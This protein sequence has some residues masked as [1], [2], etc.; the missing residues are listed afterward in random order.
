M[1]VTGVAGAFVELDRQERSVPRC[2]RN[3]SG[4]S[5]LAGG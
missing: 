4:V 2:G 3:G 1:S 5:Q